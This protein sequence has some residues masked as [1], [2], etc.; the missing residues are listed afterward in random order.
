LSIWYENW[1]LA[2]GTNL[3]WGCLRHKEYQ[4][5]SK[6]SME[7][8]LTEDHAMKAYWRS[9]GTV[10]HILNLGT[11]WRRVVSFT[12]QPLYPQ[13]K[14]LL[15]PFYRR[16]GEPQSPS[17]HGSE[18]KNYQLL[19]GLEHP[20]IQ[21]V[22]QRYTTELSQLLHQNYDVICIIY[23]KNKAIHI[24]LRF[25]NNLSEVLRLN[26]LIQHKILTN[27]AN[28]SIDQ[29]KCKYVHFSDTHIHLYPN[30]R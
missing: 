30:Q 3:K 18:G 21:P 4:G 16:L 26:S 5:G 19:A 23:T 8:F 22:A 27:E 6:K 25:T 2:Q 14:G 12:H 28:Q 24:H 29:Y 20:I 11:R 13:G 10:S 15:Y 7:L 1:S 17:G 9:R